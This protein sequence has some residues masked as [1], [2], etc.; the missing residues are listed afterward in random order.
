[1][2]NARLAKRFRRVEPTRKACNDWDVSEFFS[3]RSLGAFNAGSRETFPQS[4]GT[5][6][7]PSP[8]PLPPHQ[9][10][11][12]LRHHHR[13]RHIVTSLVVGC[14]KT[15]C[16]LHQLS[17]ISARSSIC[18]RV[19]RLSTHRD[20]EG[21]KKTDCVCFRRLAFFAVVAA[22]VHALVDELVILLMPGGLGQG[23]TAVLHKALYGTRKAS[24]LWQRSLR[25]VL[26]DAD[27]KASVIFASMNT[28]GDQRGTC[29]GDDLLVEADE[30]EAHLM[31]QLEGKVRARIGGKS[32]G[33]GGF[34]KLVLRYDAATKSFFW[35]SGK[36]YVQDA[37]TTLQLTGRSHEC[38]T[39]DTPGT[40]STVRGTEKLDG[41]E[42][43]AFQISLGSVMYVALD[44]AEILYA[45]KT[46]A[47]FMQSPT[48]SAMA[49]LKRSVR[50]LLGLAQAE[51]GPLQAGCAEVL[52]CVQRLGRR[53]GAETLDHWSCR[54]LRR[55]PARRCVGDAI[56]GRAVQHGGGVLRLRPWDRGWTA[57]VPL[58]DRGAL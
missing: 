44:R 58:P 46:V 32:S 9:P 43:A 30:S 28:L 1:M 2:R 27:W 29:W 37:T 16:S 33:E 51:S 7:H 19:L 26:S 56:A 22:F 23:R 10:Y 48:K 36:R 18:Q 45:T 14:R 47:L 3:V 12:S 24:R 17:P 31:K 13:V 42:T 55:S 8:C 5:R 4:H 49:K 11:A 54:D 40:T 15:N 20:D 38:K 41:N 39:A 50:Y 6:P 35:C 21:A 57:N 52:G 53:R 25:D 34:L